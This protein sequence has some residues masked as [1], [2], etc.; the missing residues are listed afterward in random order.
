MNVKGGGTIL[1]APGAPKNYSYL[2]IFHLEWE[3]CRNVHG[4]IYILFWYFNF[5]IK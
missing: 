1:R 4:S 2:S 3:H 5:G